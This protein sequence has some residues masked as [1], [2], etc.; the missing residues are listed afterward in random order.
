[1]SCR[2][3][4]YGGE[5]GE[6]RGGEGRGGVGEAKDNV[7]RDFTIEHVTKYLKAERL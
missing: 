6:W 1:M 2:G 3:L 5:G 7:K 4:G